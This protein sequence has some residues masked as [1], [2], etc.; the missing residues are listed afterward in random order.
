MNFQLTMK[1]IDCGNVTK[2]LIDRKVKKAT[3]LYESIDY[4]DIVLEKDAEGEHANIHSKFEQKPIHLKEV[5]EHV[6]KSIEHV[7]D[8][9]YRQLKIQKNKHNLIDHTSIKDMV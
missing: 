1:N 6:A 7:F 2:E 4:I 9:F 8:R 3:E 5:S